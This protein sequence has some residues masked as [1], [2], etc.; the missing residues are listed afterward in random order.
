MAGKYKFQA[1][2]RAGAS[3]PDEQV[4]AMKER[5]ESEKISFS[6]FVN[7]LWEE[8]ESRKTALSQNSSMLQEISIAGQEQQQ[9]EQRSQ[10]DDPSRFDEKIEKMQT[11]IVEA[12][13][14]IGANASNSVSAEGKQNSVS[15]ETKLILKAIASSKTEQV[16][17]LDSM[18]K[19]IENKLSELQVAL[20]DS[21]KIDKIEQGIEAISSSAATAPASQ[22]SELDVASAVES[23]DVQVDDS[24]VFNTGASMFDAAP[25]ID[26]SPVFETTEETVVEF[27]VPASSVSIDAIDAAESAR[28]SSDQVVEQM[29]AFAPVSVAD[30]QDNDNEVGVFKDGLTE[31]AATDFLTALAGELVGDDDDDEDDSQTFVIPS[32]QHITSDS[33]VVTLKSLEL[34]TTESRVEVTEPAAPSSFEIFDATKSRATEDDYSIDELVANHSWMAAI[35]ESNYVEEDEQDEQDEDSYDFGDVSDDAW[36]GLQSLLSG[37]DDDD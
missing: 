7:A 24:V 8:N 34:S 27:S 25:Q 13:S 12:F 5:M 23:V 19:M 30:E 2:Y 16:A 20:P 26:A 18:A 35:E 29:D 4:S 11:A 36:S 21:S 31:A 28:V 14:G 22:P 37:G 10:Q 3:V 17:K 15:N 32:V 9:F 1:T 6:E 33:D